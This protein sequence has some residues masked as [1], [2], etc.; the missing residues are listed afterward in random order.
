VNQTP[1]NRPRDWPRVRGRF[2]SD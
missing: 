1:E 2:R